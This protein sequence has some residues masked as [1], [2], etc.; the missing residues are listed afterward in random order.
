MHT[1]A[2]LIPVGTALCCHKVRMNPTQLCQSPG[3]FPRLQASLSPG[4][5]RTP[6]VNDNPYK[7]RT[8]SDQKRGCHFSTIVITSTYDIYFIKWTDFPA[9]VSPR[10]CGENGSQ[11]PSKTH[12]FPTQKRI[13]SGAR[14]ATLAPRPNGVRQF[15][16]LL[17]IN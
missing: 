5:G 2:I 3:P 7:T 15:H 13:F 10:L 1:C 16:A 12:P 9:S 14:P 17:Y 6:D 11:N 4:S 8:K